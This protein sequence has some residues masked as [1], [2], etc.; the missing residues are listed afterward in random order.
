M[1]LPYTDGD[2]RDDADDGHDDDE[3]RA[4]PIVALTFI[5]DDLHGAETESEQAEADVI[6]AEAGAFFL[7][8]VGRIADQHIGEDQRNNADRNVDEKNPAPVEIVSD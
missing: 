6:N 4:E 2:E 7:F 3:G 1:P 5:E 8:H